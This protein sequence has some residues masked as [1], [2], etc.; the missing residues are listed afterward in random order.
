[1]DPPW[2]HHFLTTTP[3]ITRTNNNYHPFHNYSMTQQHTP[4]HTL[5]TFHNITHIYQTL[6]HYKITLILY[7]LGVRLVCNTEFIHL[8]GLQGVDR[9]KRLQ[10]KTFHV[11]FCHLASLF[12]F[13]YGPAPWT[14]SNLSCWLAHIMFH[15]LYNRLPCIPPCWWL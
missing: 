8:P 1:M 12:V 6:C 5:P 10:P 7:I 13:S 2:A 15:S 3:R 4:T 11:S 9:F 14:C